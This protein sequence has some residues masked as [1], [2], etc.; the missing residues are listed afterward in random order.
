MML[1][2]G[3][4]KNHNTE[5][6]KEMEE[7]SAKVMEMVELVPVTRA[8]GLDIRP[9]LIKFYLV[10]IVDKMIDLVLLG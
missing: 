3:K 10:D 6:R 1:F 2:R 5:F 4:I 9:F 7:T 8:H